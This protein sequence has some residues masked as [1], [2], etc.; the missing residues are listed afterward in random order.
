MNVL[1]LI[2]LIYNNNITLISQQNKKKY[3]YDKNVCAHNLC[4]YMLLFV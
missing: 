1:R 4:V 2:V 3:T